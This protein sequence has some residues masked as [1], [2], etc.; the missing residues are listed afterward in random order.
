M[1][2]QEARFHDGACHLIWDLGN[3]IYMV[4]MREGASCL[5]KI[6]LKC[7]LG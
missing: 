6:T 7:A 4:D 5:L 3:R 1:H 2:S